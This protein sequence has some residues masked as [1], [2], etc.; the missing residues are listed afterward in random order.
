MNQKVK[1]ILSEG[2]PRKIRALFVF[3]K[4]DGERISKKFTLWARWFF[5]RFFSSKDA[6]FHK[7]VDN[8]TIEL[9]KNGGSFLNISFRGS[10]KTTRTKL[11]IAFC[12]AND[13][14]HYRKYFKVLSKEMNNSRQIVT[15]IY[16][17]L[18]SNRVRGL[19]PE[20]FEKSILKREETME[21][22]TT[23]SGVKVRADTIGTDQR[24]D[25]QDESRPDFL[26]FD[27]I[28]TRLS[29]MSAVITNKIWLNMEEA[30]NGLSKGGATIFNCNYIPER[31]NVHKLVQKI[32][33]QV[34]VPIE[35]NGEPTWPSRYTKD[36]VSKTKRE[37]EDY[38]GEYLCKPS[39]SKDIYFDRASLDKQVVK[40]PIE[41]IAGLKV[42][43]RYDP[44]HRIGSGHDVG[45]GVGLDSSTS[46][47]MDFDCYP[48]QV[49]AT[50]KNNEIKPDVFAHE[51][52]R[53]GKRF[54]ENYVA[55]EK[56][57][58]S[59][60]DI[61]KT[62]YPTAKIHKTERSPNKI[63]FQAPIEYGWETNSATKPKMLSEFSQALES[64]L[65]ELNDQDLINEAKS[66]TLND[67]IEKEEDPR[68]TTRHFDILM[69]ACIAWQINKFVKKVEKARNLDYW[70]SKANDNEKKNPAR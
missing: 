14:G 2:D 45:G 66:F 9:Y 51:I 21:S 8:K 35:E 19:Y 40:T 42:Y 69:A 52:A 67:F 28:E 49:I 70:E 43:K 24:G 53:Q 4:E 22:F 56:N 57:Y 26:Y 6:P 15:D 7:E 1:A 59:T 5:P 48:V 46:V 34:I 39:L 47:F 13:S 65:I 32:K 27:D 12:I 30:R 11:F 58:G 54:G 17:M 63:V 33:N 16:N 29:L 36:D 64:G 50:Y 18:V 44:S 23:A 37:A 60:L 20:I 38:E 68:L 61:L 62:I 3:D 25:I 31:G 41:E 10:S 55:V